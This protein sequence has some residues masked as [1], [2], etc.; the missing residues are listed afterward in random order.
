MTVNTAATM[1]DV[2]SELS[3]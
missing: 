2:F 1:S 3:S